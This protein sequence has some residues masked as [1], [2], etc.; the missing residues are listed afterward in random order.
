MDFTTHI[1]SGRAGLG[2]RQ[3]GRATFK[4]KPTEF[5]GFALVGQD[6]ENE[7]IEG[8]YFDI[9][10]VPELGPLSAAMAVERLARLPLHGRD[11]ALDVGAPAP[12][13]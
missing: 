2:D 3:T 8:E 4:P 6:L 5:H 12:S 7:L 13:G 11:C 1:R 9:A 10:L